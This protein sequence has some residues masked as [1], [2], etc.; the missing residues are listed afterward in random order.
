[1]PVSYTHLVC[2][3]VERLGREQIERRGGADCGRFLKG[4]ERNHKHGVD[5][6]SYTHLDVYKRQAT[7]SKE[8]QQ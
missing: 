1:M 3:A 2:E 8:V 6:V 7:R 5:P 4:I